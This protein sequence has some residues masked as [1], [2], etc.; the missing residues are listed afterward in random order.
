MSE[1]QTRLKSFIERIENLNEEL[2][3][4]KSDIKDVYTEAGDEGYNKKILRLVIKL[5]GI[6]PNELAE[7]EALVETYMSALESGSNI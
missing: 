2:A 7:Q 6:D 4:L 1:A 3:Q 5:R